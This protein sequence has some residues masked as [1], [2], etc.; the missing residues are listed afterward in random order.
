MLPIKPR[1]VFVCLITIF[2][3]ALA[4]AG[5][6]Q[7]ISYQGYLKHSGVPATETVNMVFSLY[8]SATPRNNPVWKES[9]DI[10][11]ANGIYNTQLGSVTPI[12]AP[13]DVPYYLGVQVGNDPEMSLQPL[14]G[15]G[16][17][18][19]A[20]VA[21]SALTVANPQQHLLVQHAGSGS[22]TVASSPSGIATPLLPLAAFP[23]GAPVTLT[24]TPDSYSA[25]GGWSGA[26]YGAG[27]CTV[28]MNGLST[29][30]ATFLR[31]EYTLIVSKT[32][33]GTI[34][35]TTGGLYCGAR[36]SDNFPGGTTVTLNSV[37]DPGYTAVWSGD[38]SGAISTC[39][40]NMDSSRTIGTSFGYLLSTTLS[41]T[42]AG[43]VVS[44]PT[45]INCPTGNCRTVLS[46]GT[47]VTFAA[48]PDPYS[49]FSGWTGCDSP[50]GYTC[51]FTMNQAK[52]ISAGFD[53]AY[54]TISVYPGGSNGGSGSLTLVSSP[55]TGIK[56]CSAF[57]FCSYYYLR[58]STI[59]ITAI[60]DSG[61]TFASW[62]NCPGP[63]GNVC[64]LSN[65]QVGQS[66]TAN[67]AK[68]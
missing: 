33:N 56:S 63:T 10:T 49:T 17:A 22:G 40:V 62:T 45:A 36:C 9:K 18:F 34:F 4:F 60:P 29:V 48:I 42:G 31:P 21:E 12:T 16:Y 3:A 24:A 66:I 39:S 37:P 65:I 58:S 55:V 44:T 2:V 30:I 32:G 15:T 53:Y 35:S 7:T 43:T 64:T 27:T 52:S 23:Q 13:F 61:S 67:F 14:S 46:P 68:P 8:S 20:R 11:P 41:G 1:I 26:C 25:F 5:V 19:R 54:Y 50:T 38:C 28:S 59:S 47:S 57:S 51:N 6:P